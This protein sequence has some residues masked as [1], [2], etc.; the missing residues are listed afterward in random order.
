METTRIK[1]ITWR[2]LFA[3]GLGLTLFVLVASAQIEPNA[4]QW[5]TWV[6]SSGSQFRLPEPP[7]QR[8]SKEEVEVLA[9]LATQRDANALALV[10]LWDAGSPSY[11]WNQIA[12][13][14]ISKFNLNTP[15]GE[16][17]LALVNVAIYDAMVAAWDSKYAYN[18]PRPS[19][20]VKSLSTAI[21]NPD[22]PSYPSEHPVA[23]EGGTPPHSPL[24]LPPLPKT[25]PPPAAAASPLPP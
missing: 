17:V 4:G 25:H 10:K 2:M 9:N 18:R 19:D 16:R 24:F 6:L 22:S 11:Q 1:K 3:L 21:P 12:L 23:A 5:K 7:S 13:S 14:E 8:D 15:R 20:L